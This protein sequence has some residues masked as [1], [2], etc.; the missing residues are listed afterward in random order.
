MMINGF[1]GKL[2][3]LFMPPSPQ[4]SEALIYVS[5]VSLFS[6]VSARSYNSLREDE[7]NSGDLEWLVAADFFQGTCI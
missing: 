7:I 5:F 4:A 2:T 1:L 6:F 3:S